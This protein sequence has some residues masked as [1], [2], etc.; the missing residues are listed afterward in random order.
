MHDSNVN[1]SQTARACVCAYASTSAL[2]TY[3]LHVLW[4]DVVV[5]ELLLPNDAYELQDLRQC[6]R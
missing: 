5:E 6:G 2:S 4:L 3:K 1:T